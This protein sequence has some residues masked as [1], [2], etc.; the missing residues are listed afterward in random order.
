MPHLLLV[1]IGQGASMVKCAK[2]ML[3]YTK[4]ITSVETPKVLAKCCLYW[5]FFHADLYC[6]VGY[7]HIEYQ[8]EIF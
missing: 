4:T 1:L 8:D 5:I 2:K 3:Q 6:C 7:S